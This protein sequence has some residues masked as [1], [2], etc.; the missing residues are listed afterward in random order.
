MQIMSI[1]PYDVNG[2]VSA[3]KHT[4]YFY[5][6]SSASNLKSTQATYLKIADYIHIFVQIIYTKFN[7]DRANDNGDTECTK[8]NLF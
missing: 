5:L 2:G 8:L 3:A 7:N 1:T 4:H 6:F